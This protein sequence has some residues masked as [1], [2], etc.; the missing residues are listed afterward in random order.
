ML[1]YHHFYLRRPIFGVTYFLTFGLC[2][3]GWVVDVFRMPFLVKKANSDIRQIRDAEP[4]ASIWDEEKRLDDA[5]TLSFP[6]GFLGLH[7]F[8]L[9]R[10]FFGFMYLFTFGLCGFGTVVDWFRLPCLV[11][12]TNTE[13]R[14]DKRDYR[15]LFDA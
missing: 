1:G 9:N 13:I 6:L 5:Y 12:R 4:I 14:E 7:H 15:N 8:Y 11:K 2:G 3:V 10:I